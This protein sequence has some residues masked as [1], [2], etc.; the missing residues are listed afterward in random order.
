MSDWEAVIG[1]EVHA[2]LQTRTKIFCGC[3]T[4]FGAPVRTPEIAITRKRGPFQTTFTNGILA[5]QWLRNVLLE[6]GVKQPSELISM[7]AHPPEVLDVSNAQH[8]RIL[9]AVRRHDATAAAREM[10][11]H[12]HAT[13]Y[14]LAGLLPRV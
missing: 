11:E 7:I 4:R 8:R 2:Q 9:A 12:L 3:S 10:T 14:V 5:A 1:L 13:E 6:D